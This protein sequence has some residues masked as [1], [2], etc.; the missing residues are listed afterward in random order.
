M[1]TVIDASDR[2]FLPICACGWR[3][4]PAITRS[5]ALSDAR[6]HEKRAHEADH[7]VQRALNAAAWRMA[8]RR[9]QV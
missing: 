2:T 8:T 5:A 3:G 6:E 7:D 9:S 4:L 1:K